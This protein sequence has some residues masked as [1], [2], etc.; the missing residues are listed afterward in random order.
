[1]DEPLCF[2]RLQ[3]ARITDLN[4]ALGSQ[5][6]IACDVCVIG[7]GAAGLYIANRLARQGVAVTVVEAGG[8]T[9]G[10]GQSAGI[11]SIFS[12]SHYRGAA[13]GRAFGW[14]G[15]TSRWGGLLVP[16]SELDIRQDAGP[17]SSVW[18]HVVKVVRE[19][20]SAVFSTLGFSGSPDFFSFPE[21]VLGPVTKVLLDQGL[22]TIASEF[23]PLTRRNLVYLASGRAQESVHVVLNA[24]VTKWF[25][26]FEGHHSG[27]V[28]TIEATSLRGTCLRVSAK[29]FVIAAG[30][31]ESA[32][33]LLELDRASD[34]RML[35]RAAAVGR[36]LSD[37]LSRP[38]ADVHSDDRQRAAAIFAPVFANGRMRSFRFVE[39]SLGPQARRHF[40]HFVFDGS[41]PGFRLAKDLLA[42]LQGR[43]LP[44]VTLTG[45]STGLSGLI[46]LAYSRFV[47][48]RLFIPQATTSRL[49]LDIEQ[50]PAAENRVRLG[51]EKDKFGRPMAIIHWRIGDADCSAMELLSKRFMASW[52]AAT[53]GG[54]RLVSIP[55]ESASPKPNDAYHPVGTCR[56]GD[57]AEATVDWDLK[58]RGT[59]NLFVLSTGVLPSAGT[60]NPTFSML[61][62]GDKLG[63]TLTSF[64]RVRQ[65]H[66]QIVA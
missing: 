23:L 8:A 18:T 26:R 61:C 60:A 49:Q 28:S 45:V 51:E 11:E 44:K 40:A 20:S 43:Y 9:C 36:Y 4:R 21:T 53:L 19:R 27:E 13:E 48:S 29:C 31:I 10:S 65:L 22:T 50:L 55:V 59:K 30:A 6:K 7:A 12:G 2:Q 37:H 15:S 57:D 46:G 47:R 54:V 41:N 5:P 56:L 17:L 16:H 33:I 58:V 39:T 63:D 38:V 34:G 25:V 3:M 66:E 42:G 52:P 24:V 62:L 64:T 35:P 32:R 1:V 14:G